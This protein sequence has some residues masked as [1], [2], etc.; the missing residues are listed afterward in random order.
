MNVLVLASMGRCGSTLLFKAL[1]ANFDRI[2]FD[3][4]LKSIYDDGTLVKTHDFALD[5]MQN[6]K[7]IYL[8]GDPRDVAI[9]AHTKG[10]VNTNKHYSHMHASMNYKK[11]RG[12]DQS[13]FN[14]DTLR[15]SDNFNS[16]YK[17]QSCPLIT[18]KY[19][20]LYDNLDV[21]NDFLGFEVILPPH[22]QRSTNW[23]THPKSKILSETYEK[24]IK[25][26]EAA[27]QIKIWDIKE[28]NRE[29]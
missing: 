17:Q 27:D 24:L 11:A 26:I 13:F 28:N 9:S 6:Y 3:K 14:K 23:S 2:K 1:G 21:L 15:L 22:R 20:T 7:A 8:F 19:E 10:K 12:R 29:L 5:E 18:I 16:W 4:D 25:Q